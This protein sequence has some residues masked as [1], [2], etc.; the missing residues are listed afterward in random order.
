[1][2]RQ[3]IQIYKNIEKWPKR[4]ANLCTEMSLSIRRFIVSIV[5]VTG[6]WLGLMSLPQTTVNVWAVGC[7]VAVI[8]TMSVSIDV[9]L[10]YEACLGKGTAKSA[11]LDRSRGRNATTRTA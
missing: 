8:H 7:A 4:T 11:T 3:I 2:S 6:C 9:D 1:M 10:R 5:L